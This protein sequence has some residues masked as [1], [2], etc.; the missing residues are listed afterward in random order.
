MSL[1]MG[2][3]PQ[4]TGF[5][6]TLTYENYVWKTKYNELW[7]LF[8]QST[9]D[10]KQLQEQTSKHVVQIPSENINESQVALVQHLQAKQTELV[11]LIIEKNI[12]IAQL[13]KEVLFEKHKIPISPP[14]PSLPINQIP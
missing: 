11:K 5:L 13:Q 7:K 2:D 8:L 14:S 1:E 12:E 4:L 6:N 3:H 10:L 9:N